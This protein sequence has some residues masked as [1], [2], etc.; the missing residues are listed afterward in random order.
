[1]NVWDLIH[2]DPGRTKRDLAVAHTY[3]HT[4][5]SSARRAAEWVTN[6]LTGM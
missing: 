4:D 6:R 5:G 2:D 3:A 1:M